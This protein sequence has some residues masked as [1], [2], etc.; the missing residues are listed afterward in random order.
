MVVRMARLKA[1][2]SDGVMG[3]NNNFGHGMFVCMYKSSGVLPV[4]RRPTFPWDSSASPF[5]RCLG[6]EYDQSF[7]SS[8]GVSRAVG[9]SRAALTITHFAR[10]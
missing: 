9:L 2:M 10:G 4:V 3:C 8:I 6:M 5:T 7:Y 1:V